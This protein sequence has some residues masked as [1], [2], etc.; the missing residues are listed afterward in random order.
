MSVRLT[1]GEKTFNKINVV[2]M[3][4]LSSLFVIPFVIVISTSL[5]SAPEAARRGGLVLIPE[6][7]DLGAYRVLFGH[8]SAIIR[9]Y[10]VTIFRVVVGTALNLAFT[11]TLAYGLSK[12][13]LPG[14]NT[15]IMFVLFT[16]LFNGGLIPFFL[17]VKTIGLYNTRWALIIPIRS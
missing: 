11:T 9:S 12:K 13:R 5:V 10:G 16:M 7:V 3:I 14:R 4:L 17:V 2:L 6:N 8:G 1:K 15:I